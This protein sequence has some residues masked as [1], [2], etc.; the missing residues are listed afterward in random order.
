MNL[1][2][3]LLGRGCSLSKDLRSVVE[4]GDLYVRDKDGTDVIIVPDLGSLSVDGLMGGLQVATRDVQTVKNIATFL[5]TYLGA[6]KDRISLY[7]EF[8]LT[9]ASSRNINTLLHTDGPYLLQVLDLLSGSVVHDFLHR[10]S[11]LATNPVIDSTSLQKLRKELKGLSKLYA[12]CNRS[13]GWASLDTD[14]FKVNRLLLKV[15]WFPRDI[16]ELTFLSEYVRTS[17]VSDSASTE[18]AEEVILLFRLLYAERYTSRGAPEGSYLLGTNELLVTTPNQNTF[19][20]EGRADKDRTSEDEA[21]LRSIRHPLR[22]HL[23]DMQYIEDGHNLYKKYKTYGLKNVLLKKTLKTAKEASEYNHAFISANCVSL[24]L[25]EQ[26]VPGTP[27]WEPDKLPDSLEKYRV[28]TNESLEAVGIILK[29]CVATR[30]KEGRVFYYSAEHKAVAQVNIPDGDTS[31]A[32]EVYECRGISNTRNEGVIAFEGLLKDTLSEWYTAS[33][34]GTRALRVPGYINEDTLTPLP[35]DAGLTYLEYRNAGLT[36]NADPTRTI[37]LGAYSK[38][39]S[40]DIHSARDVTVLLPTNAGVHVK[41]P[42][43]TTTP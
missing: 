11:P 26:G 30:K 34:E 35:G 24:N 7:L 10:Y 40:L 32:P 3:A 28:R 14:V 8:I 19:W 1:Q 17:G 15:K 36:F 43:N 23:A 42:N 25:K 31:R 22:V 12:F 27:L 21:R 33:S 2:Q 20:F 41:I 18:D 9:S 4:D 29:N 37:S 6:A 5:L 16:Q 13:W 38:S 39:I